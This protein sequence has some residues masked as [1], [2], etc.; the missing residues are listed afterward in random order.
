M[1]P[2]SVLLWLTVSV[3]AL[4]WSIRPRPLVSSDLHGVSQQLAQSPNASQSQLVF[5][6]TEKTAAESQASDLD[7]EQPQGTP[8]ITWDLLQTLNFADGSMSEQLRALNGKRVRVPGFIVP[9]DDFQDVVK[10]FLL[11]PYYGA[12]VHTPPP[13]PNQIVLVRMKS[14]KQ[15]VSLFEPVWIE[16]VLAIK[17]Y[18]SI[19]GSVGFQISGERVSPYR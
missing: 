17:Q 4:G 9:L 18:K 11:V 15:K 5:K 3:I 8:A 14:G 12:C 10:E 16:G 2:R 19:Y 6:P 13:P 1:G 7:E